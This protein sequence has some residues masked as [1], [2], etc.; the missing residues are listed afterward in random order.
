MGREVKRVDISFN[1][2]L[3]KIWQGYI[4]P[5]YKD[6]KDCPF[7]NGSGYNK[8]TKRISDE[9]YS[10]EDRSKQ[11]CHNITQDEVQALV[12]KNRLMNF[13]HTFISG[14]GWIKKDPAY[15]PTAEEVNEWSKTRLGHDAINQWICVEARAK[16]LGVYGNCEYCNG[17]GVIWLNPVSKDNYNNWKSEE[18][19]E[20]NAYQLWETT[21]EGS[22]C[23]PP[24]NTPEELAQYCVDSRVSSFASNTENYDTWLSFIRDKGFACSMVSSSNGI[25]SGVKAVVNKKC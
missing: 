5:Y 14:K 2:P 15:I 19:P 10:F 3:N 20:G 8:A 17:E 23:T 24:F 4:N 16:R 1:W 9:W 22:P 25:Q 13:T 7:C 11:W 21:S 12:D 18:P 6:Q